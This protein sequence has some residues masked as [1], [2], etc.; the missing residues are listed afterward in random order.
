MIDHHL[1]NKEGL[2]L[3]VLDNAYL[4]LRWQNAVDYFTLARLSR[5]GSD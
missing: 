1:G 2:Y 5:R 3:A 4:V